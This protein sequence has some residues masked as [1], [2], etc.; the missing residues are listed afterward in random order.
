MER[1]RD[2]LNWRYC[3]PRAGGFLVTQAEE[4]GR[5]VGFSAPKINHYDPNY[6]VG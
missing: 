4:N 6:P 2:Y 1:N 3:D 5:L